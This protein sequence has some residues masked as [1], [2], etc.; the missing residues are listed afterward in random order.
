MHGEDCE[1]NGFCF[2]EKEGIVYLSDI[3]RMPTK[4]LEYIKSWKERKARSDSKFSLLVLD[5]LFFQGEHNTHF[6][7]DDCVK[8]VRELKPERVLLVGMSCDSVPEHSE[9]NKILRKLFEDDG[10]DCQLAYDGQKIH[11]DL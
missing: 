3:S 2:G 9:A 1:C 6:C 11:F 4:T 5:C 8:L 10:I 7:L